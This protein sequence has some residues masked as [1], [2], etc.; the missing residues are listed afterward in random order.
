M[1]DDVTLDK[2]V[3]GEEV[4]MTGKPIIFRGD[5]L[6]ANEIKRLSRKEDPTLTVIFDKEKENLE[7]RLSNNRGSYF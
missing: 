5:E 7:M 2:M 6:S 4:S 3:N 1:S